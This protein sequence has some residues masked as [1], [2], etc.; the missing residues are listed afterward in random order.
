MRKHA[1]SYVNYRGLHRTI[2]V[3]GCPD[4]EVVR[5][6]L[7]WALDTEVAVREIL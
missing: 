1:F 3:R 2:T 7:E 6:M 4:I 5:R